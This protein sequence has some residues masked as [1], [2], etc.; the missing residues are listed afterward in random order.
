MADTDTVVPL[1]AVR[2]DRAAGA[3]FFSV[4][5]GAWLVLW[6]HR[7][8]ADRPGVLGPV[9]VIALSVLAFVYYRYRHFGRGVVAVEDSAEKKKTDRIF[10]FVNAG[11][12]IAILVL[13]NVLANIGK[14]DW[15]LPA[16]MFIIGL[17][18]LPL[19]KI[20]ANPSH[21]VTGAALMFA[22][23]AYPQFAA[24]G[25]ADPVGCLAA[26]AILLASALWAV[27]ANPSLRID[28]ARR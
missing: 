11:Q 16:A 9:L 22:S 19:G 17:H 8:F 24:A 14:S 28:A 3:M 5:G 1:D 18:L 12:W 15:V 4:F 21:Y 25:A 7:G 26:G 20:F 23:V 13:G 10:H 6:A 27:T 2:R